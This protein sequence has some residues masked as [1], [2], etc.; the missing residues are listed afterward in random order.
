M[1]TQLRQ[2]FKQIQPFDV[3]PRLVYSEPRVNFFF[4]KTVF[5]FCRYDYSF[6]FSLCFGEKFYRPLPILRIFHKLKSPFCIF[7]V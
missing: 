4:G 1:K 3:I 6:I 5:N 2:I 7:F